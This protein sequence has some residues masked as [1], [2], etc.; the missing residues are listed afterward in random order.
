[1]TQR[2]VDYTYGT[3][4]PVLP[5]G[6]IDVRDGIDNLQSFDILMNA[7]DDTYNQRDGGIVLTVAGALKKTG[8]KPGVG[9]F[10]TGFTVM[11]GER[12]I[13]WYDQASQNWYSYL[14]IIPTG[15]Y[16]VSP[17]TNPVGDINWA[18]RTD[19][20]LRTELASTSGATLMRGSTGRTQ[21]SKNGD[22]I[23]VA[24]YGLVGLTDDTAVIQAA[25]LD[26]F[27]KGLPL[28]FTPLKYG[29]YRSR[30]ILLPQNSEEPVKPL[31][32]IGNGSTIFVLGTDHLFSVDGDFFYDL[33]VDGLHFESDYS[34]NFASTDSK[35]FN[36]KKLLRLIVTNCSSRYVNKFFDCPWAPPQTAADYAQSVYATNCIYRRGNTDGYFFQAPVAFDVSLTDC[37]VEQS[38]NGIRVVSQ[39][40][41]GNLQQVSSVRIRGGAWESLFGT[42]MAFGPVHQLS[43]NGVYFEGNTTDINLS[44]NGGEAPHLGVD[45]SGNDFYL[46]LA[47]ISA[48]YYP[49][50]WGANASKSYKTGGNKSNGNLHDINGATGVFDFTGD[51][52]ANNL[53]NGMNANNPRSTTNAPVGKVKFLTSEGAWFFNDL[54][55][56]R[57]DI[58]LGGTESGNI[59]NADLVGG[60]RVWPKQTTGALNP[61][62]SPATYGNTA[63][64]KGSFVRNS[65]PTILGTSGSQY[66]IAGWL[67]VTSGTGGQAGTDRWVENRSFIGI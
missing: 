47:Q 12:D 13:A 17:G 8:F 58:T 42:A 1:M 64:C 43:V 6:S 51:S 48:G 30:Q 41:V 59:A 39:P 45:I 9:D 49:I 46:S 52:A 21:E 23:T 62:D 24:D 56:I 2:V 27:A 10:T 61:Q 28:V 5:N 15:G 3:G 50:I 66:V 34:G 33:F 31:H 44:Y 55:L 22:Y 57:E 11:P 63:W 32:V 65:S 26:A 16:T 37:L 4:N 53:Y 25:A 36:T 67:C 60:V 54:T 38:Y 35:I 18:P 19:H 40:A 14:G 29:M 7:S 20:V